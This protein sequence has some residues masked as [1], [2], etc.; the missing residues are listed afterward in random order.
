[1][2]VV[3]IDGGWAVRIGDRVAQR[4]LTEVAAQAYVAKANAALAKASDAL[5]KAQ[6]RPSP[7]PP[8]PS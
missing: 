2:N 3:N 4:F 1:M 8:T 7:R 5:A 6:R